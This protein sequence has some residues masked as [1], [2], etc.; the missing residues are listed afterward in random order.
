MPSG[1]VGG[2]PEA[3]PGPSLPIDIGIIAEQYL[4]GSYGKDGD[5]TFGLKSKGGQFYLGNAQLD[6]DGN[7][8]VINDKRYREAQGLWDLIV[9]KNPEPVFATEEVMEN[10]EE[11]MVNSGAMKHPG[12]PDRPLTCKGYKWKNIIKPIW[13][14]R[15]KIPK[16]KAKR[17]QIKA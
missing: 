11:I 3:L 14:K 17:E 8:L 1:Q 2:Q 6:V 9:M 12:N 10:C 5:K 16:Q 4:L 7:D 15:V 13:D